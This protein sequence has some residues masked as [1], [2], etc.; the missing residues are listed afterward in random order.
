MKT[1]IFLSLIVVVIL[2]IQQAFASSHH[3]PTDI[4]QSVC[5]GKEGVT[6]AHHEANLNSWKDCRFKRE[7]LVEWVR[8]FFPNNTR[9]LTMEECQRVRSHYLKGPELA[10][11]ESCE[12]VFVR[13][14]CNKDGVIDEEDL[15]NTGDYCIKDCK[16]ANRL[17]YCIGDRMLDHNNPFGETKEPEAVDPALIAD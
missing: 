15:E 10:V 1:L 4:L 14:D 12:T 17:F 5:V 9:G 7:D 13:C 2:T 3:R 6:R 8:I 11:L 16:A